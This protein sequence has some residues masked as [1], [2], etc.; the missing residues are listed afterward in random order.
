MSLGMFDKEL[1]AALAALRW[2]VEDPEIKERHAEIL[3]TAYM[4]NSYEKGDSFPNEKFVEWD[5]INA[6]TTLEIEAAARSLIID[7][8][9]YNGEDDLLYGDDTYP[10]GCCMCCGCSCD[11]YMWEDDGSFDDDDWGDDD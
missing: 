2:V 8:E 3:N 6:L 5:F 9:S 4:E 7:D 1:L 11:D 10:C